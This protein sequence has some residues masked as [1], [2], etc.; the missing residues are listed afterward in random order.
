MCDINSAIFNINLSTAKPETGSLLVAEP[1]LREEYFNH[2]VICLVDHEEGKSTMGLVLN[3]DTGYTL[4]DIIDEIETDNEIPIFCGGPMSPDRLFYIHTL[5]SL[6]P[7]SRK[8]SDELYIGGD[9]EEIMKYINNGYPTDGFI[10]FFIGYSG[11]DAG[12]LES[13]MSNHVWAVTNLPQRRHILRGSEDSYW[14]RTV[15]GM[16][17]KFRGW[18]YHP[19]DIHAN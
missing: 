9:F 16:G 11:W 7:G 14:H 2:A 5:G 6:F 12:Q 8:I 3:R 19:M 17:E 4:G 10:R 13:E 18:L 15:R 1:F